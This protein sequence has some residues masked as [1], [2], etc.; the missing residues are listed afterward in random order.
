MDF[1]FLRDYRHNYRFFSTESVHQIQVEFSRL[2]KVW[3]AA[4]KKLMLL[5]PKILRQ[6]QAFIRI[7][8]LEDEKIQASL[9]DFKQENLTALLLWEHVRGKVTVM[10]VE[11]DEKV[12]TNP[13]LNRTRAETAIKKAKSSDLINQLYSQIYEKFHVKKLSENFPAVAE[14]HQRLLL[15]PKKRRKAWWI[16]SSQVKEELTP[17]EKNLVLVSY[18]GG[19]VTLEDWFKV[20]CNFSPPSRPKNLDTTKGI[21]RLVDMAMRGPLFTA[22]AVSRGLQ[23]NKDYQRKLREREDLILFNMALAKKTEGIEQLQTETELLDY[24]NKNKQ[25]FRTPDRLRIDPIWCQDLETARKAKAEL[26]SNPA[27]FESVKQKYSLEEPEEPFVTVPAGEGVFFED[28]WNSE[29]N[30]II[31]PVK[32]FHGDRVLWRIVKILEK[33]PGELQE[34]SSNLEGSVKS[35]AYGEQRE[36]ILTEYRK[37]LLEKY[38][39]RIY[40]DR[41]PDPLDIQ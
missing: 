18:D 14:I 17:E 19:K 10:D 12:K 15:H 29:L 25:A 24:F 39:Y 16:R 8:K 38:P 33:T 31:G 11:V 13:K 1:F 2:K 27:D 9:K 20:L 22:E 4:K 35:K 30:E 3:T 28:L 6:E 41:I 5:P 37:E 21:E 7:L 36:A 34:Y 23:N 40:R 32:G 26:D